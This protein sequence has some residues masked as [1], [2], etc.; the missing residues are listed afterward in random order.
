MRRAVGGLLALVVLATM[1]VGLQVGVD[2]AL[3]PTPAGAATI[4][5]PLTFTSPRS[6]A[7]DPASGRVFVSGGD[8][9]DVFAPD[10]TR[11]TTISGIPAAGGLDIAGTS[12]WVTSGMSL[13]EMDLSTLGVVRTVPTPFT[14]KRD[15]VVIGT[16]AFASI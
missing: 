11:T 13:I 2:V 1:V 14:F 12:L 6:M 16:K 15:L 5:T 7:V 9:I 3:A 4:T 10:G 8:A